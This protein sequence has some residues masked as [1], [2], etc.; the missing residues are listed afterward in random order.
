MR[1]FGAGPI[2]DRAALVKA[3][4]IACELEHGLSLQYLY[5]A[6]TLRTDPDDGLTGAELI[7][8][9]SW[10]A[11]IFFVAAQEM[12]HLAQA[13]N[14][15]LS[16]G[17]APHL[18][19][20]DFPQPAGHYPPDLGWELT[21]FDRATIDR[22][23]DYE[24]TLPPGP[25]PPHESIGQLYEAIAEAF[26]HLDLPDDEL[27][28][29]DPGHQI[30]GDMVDFPLLIEVVDRRTAV[31]ACRLIM[32]EGEGSAADHADCHEGI[33][34]KILGELDQVGEPARRVAASPVLEVRGGEPHGTR[35]TDP[36]TRTVQEISNAAYDVLVYALLGFFAGGS[37]DPAAPSVKAATLQLMT[38][39]IRPLGE[40]LT[41]LPMGP[42]HEGLNAGPS[43]EIGSPS[44][45]PP[46]GDAA[47][48]EMAQRLERAAAA[49]RRLA[50]DP[51][52]PPSRAAVLDG[53]AGNLVRCAALLWQP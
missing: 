14:L 9:R 17:G 3:L 22:F 37:R 34:R 6:F 44:S 50:D 45:L 27:F 8:V 33:F 21:G 48:R 28:V 18:A 20:P 30:T 7:R 49:A 38:T 40:L 47:R 2:P 29:G 4:T 16:I 10:A 15:L 51:T 53:I 12:M 25:G 39:V 36:F 31:E 11:S 43:F 52:L 26:E 35:I 41:R 5:A 32:V 23:V 13:S 19:R 24:S 1:S 42:G 46:D